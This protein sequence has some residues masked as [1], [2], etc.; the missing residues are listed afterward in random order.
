[1]SEFQDDS[2]LADLRTGAARIGVWGAG[3]IGFSTMANFANSGIETRAYDI[4][5]QQVETINDGEIP[6]DT[7]EYWLGFQTDDLVEAGLMRADTDHADLLSADTRVHFVAIPTEKDG[8]PWAEPLR[9]TAARLA[10]SEVREGEPMVVIVESTL[11]PGMAE[12]VVMPVFEESALELG[13]DVLVGVAPRRDWFTSRKRGLTDIPR[14]FGGQNDRATAYMDS[15]LSVVCDNLVE[16]SDHT[17]AEMVKS[18]ENA[19]R[20]MGITLA[21]QLA[22]AYPNK[23]IREVLELAATKWNIPAYF[24]S[25]G[26]GGYCIPQASKYVVDG[27]ENAEELSIMSEVIRTDESHPELIADVIADHG[28]DSVTILGLAYKGDVKVDVLSP[29]KD[30]ARRLSERGVDVAVN[31]PYFDDEYIREQT[32]ATPVAFPDGLAGRDA[33]V[34][35]AGHRQY[36]Y[37][38]QADVLSNLTD[39]DLIIDSPKVWDDLELGDTDT[40]YFYTGGAGW[41]GSDQQASAVQTRTDD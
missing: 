32:G 38:P 31:D 11:T 18:V 12:E 6:I 8:D 22:R 26:I 21:N 28:V 34:V 19:Y 9:Q 17:H 23:D 29:T 33:V 1:M 40:E 15:V 10:E 37:T 4:D 2:L 7:L 25:I 27:A 30:I 3:F 39:C 24:P 20:H 16:A 35:A 41:L 13:E 36:T 14:V 5:P